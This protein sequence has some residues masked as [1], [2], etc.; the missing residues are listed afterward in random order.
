MSEYD[1]IADRARVRTG[2]IPD[3]PDVLWALEWAHDQL[4]RHPK[5]C[6]ANHPTMTAHH[7]AL[8]AAI[9]KHRENEPISAAAPYLLAALEGMQ[10]GK[11]CF[12]TCHWEY[13]GRHHAICLEATYAIAKARGSA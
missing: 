13:S 8:L 6:Q 3:N 2:P 9:A 12:D 1:K 11:G 4:C 7:D 10:T 5:W